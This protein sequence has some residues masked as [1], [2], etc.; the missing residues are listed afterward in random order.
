MVVVTAATGKLGA[1]VVSTL[2]ETVPAA[3]VAVVVRQPDKATAY[4]ARG[5]EVRHADYAK[6]DTLRS[7]FRKGD[8]VLFVSSS[9]AGQRV[10]QHGNVID[11]AKA[12]GVDLLAYTSILHGEQ[13]RLEL[14]AEHVAT[15]KAIRASGLPFVFLRNGWY[16]EN[17][18]E[19]LDAA[20]ASGAIYGSAGDGRI[21]AAARAD[22][23]VAAARVLTDGAHANQIYELAGD[24]PFTKAELAAEVAKQSGKPVAYHDLPGEAYAAALVRVGLPPG[25]AAVLADS[26]VGIAR[27]ELDDRSGTL[28][29]LIGRPTTT[30]A[31]AIAAALRARGA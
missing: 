27:G 9:E 31:A 10:V 1:H 30:L 11:A 29:R 18:T 15:E 26:D 4:V 22:Y 21:A 23:A 28:R 2:L 25:Y 6:P 14:A 24:E 8:R 12:A 16:L 13:S 7:A 17:Y 3:E 20:L 19:H 5:I